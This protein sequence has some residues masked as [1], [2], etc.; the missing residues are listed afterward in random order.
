MLTIEDIERFDLF[1]VGT[2]TNLPFDHTFLV[3]NLL[4]TAH[5]NFSHNRKEYGFL[6]E[7]AKSLAMEVSFISVNWFQDRFR[8]ENALQ[9]ASVQCDI[10]APHLVHYN[11][12][13]PE[14]GLFEWL[15]LITPPVCYGES[16]ILVRLYGNHFKR[17]F[18]LKPR[19]LEHLSKKNLRRRP[20]FHHR[21]AAIFRTLRAISTSSIFL[22]IDHRCFRFGTTTLS[23]LETGSPQ[24]T[25]IACVQKRNHELHQKSLYE[26]N[27]KTEWMGS[28]TRPQGR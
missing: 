5:L 14:F 11:F 17:S 24:A 12:S 15:A 19:W 8:N 27:P 9:S 10:I 20:E 25:A 18:R 3:E 7:D 13:K 22:L 21:T 2:A 1:V 23:T 16:R 6:P 26:C 4:D 28:W